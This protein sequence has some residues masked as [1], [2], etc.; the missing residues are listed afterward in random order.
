MIGTK[1]FVS[2]F[3]TGAGRLWQY[4][5]VLDT[6]TVKLNGQS[7]GFYSEG[8]AIGNYGYMRLNSGGQAILRYTP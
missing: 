1:A 4:D 5:A 2:I 7:P 3:T 6:W 8:F